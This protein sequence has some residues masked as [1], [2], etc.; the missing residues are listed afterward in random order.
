M[1]GEFAKD[2]RIKNWKKITSEFPVRDRFTR[3]TALKKY[4]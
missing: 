1:V 2:P 4:D 3:I